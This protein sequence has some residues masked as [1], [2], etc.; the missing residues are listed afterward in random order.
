MNCASP[1]SS[2]AARITARAP[3]NRIVSWG[4]HSTSAPVPARSVVSARAVRPADRYHF[5]APGV[6]TCTC[7]ART[8]VDVDRQRIARNDATRGMHDDHLAHVGALGIERPL[9]AERTDVP[10]RGE[11]RA[12]PLP[13]ETQR[14]ARIPSGR[15]VL[16][17]PCFGERGFGHRVSMGHGAGQS[18][19]PFNATACA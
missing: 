19:S 12:R 18:R 17:D 11:H 2:M 6:V 1:A 9:N 10:A 5:A 16:D 15:R 13:F 4:S 7:V 3:S 14:E 8:G